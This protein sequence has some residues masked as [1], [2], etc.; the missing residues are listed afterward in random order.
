M[1]QP[2]HSNP[3]IACVIM[4]AI[5]DIMSDHG[6]AICT[7]VDYVSATKDQV[8]IIAVL[9]RSK[10]SFKFIMR[11]ANDDACQYHTENNE[12]CYN[13]SDP[14]LMM[15]EICEYVTFICRNYESIL[16]CGGANGFGGV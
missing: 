3:L 4:E 7:G 10:S 11:M 16:G 1:H 9:C 5:S 14:A 13:D 8:I 15:N 12:L 6:F 2:A